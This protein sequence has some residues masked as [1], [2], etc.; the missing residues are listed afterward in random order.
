MPIVAPP[1]E[2]HA[3]AATGISG[4]PRALPHGAQIQESFGDEHDLS[5]IA[6]H[7]GGAAAVKI[8]GK[9]AKSWPGAAC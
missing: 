4:A 1:I 9:D 8:I 5:G 7:V 3:T 2:V 6:A